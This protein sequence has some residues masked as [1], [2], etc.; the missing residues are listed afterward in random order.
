[1]CKHVWARTYQTHV[2]F[3]HIDEL[4]QLVDVGVPHEQSPF[5]DTRVVF[6]CLYSVRILVHL[7]AA[8]LVAEEIFAIVTCS[9]LF[10]EDRA[11]H[12]DFA[13]DGYNDEYEGE[14]CTQE[15]QCHNKVET[16]LEYSFANI[17][18]WFRVHG[19]HIDIPKLL[20]LGIAEFSQ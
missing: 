4:W 6:H 1:M 12:G 5:G 16:A 11:R 17:H 14:E 7:H 10:E 3:Q 9:F 2:A 18:Q 8:E 15:Q 20:D 13:D 19:H